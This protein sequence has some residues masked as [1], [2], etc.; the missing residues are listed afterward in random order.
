MNDLQVGG[1]APFSLIERTIVLAVGGS[2]AYGI[3]KIDSDVDVKG[4]AV[5][6]KAQFLGFNSGFEQVDKPGHMQVFVQHMNADEQQ[7][8]TATKLEG[9][10]FDVRKFFKLA[11]ESNP[12][13]L[14][15]LFCRDEE[16][17]I[18]TPMGKVLRDN[19]DLFISAKAKHTFS[20]YAAAQLKRI[21][22]HRAWLLTPPKAQPTRA[23]FG[24]PET[25]LIPA[26]QLAAAEASVRKQL[27]LWGVDCTGMSEAEVINFTTQA[28][29]WMSRT[30]ISLGF[31]QVA[32]PDAQW[33]AAA[34]TV[35]L[36][37][38]LIYVMQKEREYKS[39][40]NY[41]KQY[42]E[43]KTNRNPARAELEAK[44]GYDTKHGA[45]L[46]RLLRMGRE[47]MET[48]KVH[49]WRGAGSGP[50]DREE[51]LAIRGGE[52]SYDKLIE[53]ASA[54][55]AD[56]ERRYKTGDYAL[57]HAPD[58]VRLDKLC[59]EIVETMLAQ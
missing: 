30:Q 53:W 10:V 5:P 49:V 57:P 59:V 17:R 9:V 18:C 31:G 7:V 50:N 16:V 14:D 46:V 45:H 41:W 15:V 52:W 44:Y 42:Q 28:T 26:D 54:E 34:R 21:K 37:E 24:L 32:Q 1:A 12:N 38:N 27:D 47:I 25:T 51:L 36:T 19:R 13:I 4:V 48:G 35:G 20:G 55:D 2:R 22:G 40:Q 58:R 43:W 3:H 33:L 6:G 29:E 11:A 23:D 56:L 8:I 39:A